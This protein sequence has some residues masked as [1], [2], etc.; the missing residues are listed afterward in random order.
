M[1]GWIYELDMDMGFWKKGRE[2]MR[3]PRK[4]DVFARNGLSRQSTQ[5]RGGDYTNPD[6]VRVEREIRSEKYMTV[7]IQEGSLVYESRKAHSSWTALTKKFAQL[8][9]HKRG[10]FVV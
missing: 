1:D 3:G 2:E 5:F 9:S 7:W 10:S 4:E 8:L 6:S